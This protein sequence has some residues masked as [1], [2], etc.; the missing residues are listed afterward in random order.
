MRGYREQAGYRSVTQRE[1]PAGDHFLTPCR[2]RSLLTAMFRTAMCA[3]ACAVALSVAPALAQ[4][5]PATPAPVAVTLD[6]STTALLVLDI[7]TQ[8]CGNQPRCQEF[9]PRVSGLL[10]NARQSGVYVLYSSWR[11]HSPRGRDRT[12]WRGRSPRGRDRT[13]WRGSSLAGVNRTLWRGHSLGS[14][15]HVLARTFTWRE[16]PAPRR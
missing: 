14:D 3:A 11:G 2:P 9:L 6:P 12:S 8:A 16:R 7:T 15:S 4:Q 13:S 1:S 10:A 5:V